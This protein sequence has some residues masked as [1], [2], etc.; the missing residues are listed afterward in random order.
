MSLLNTAIT[1]IN[2]YQKQLTTVGNNISNANT[3]G[4]S[5]QEVIISSAPSQFVG[6]GYEGSGVNIDTI[7]RL[8]DQ[9]A[10]EQLRVDTNLFKGHESFRD[11]VEQINQLLGD[12]RTGLN[13]ALNQYFSS[14]QV[15]SEAPGFIP[16]REAL[17]GAGET[18][19]DRFNVVS[20]RL[21]DQNKTVNSTISANASDINALAAG[22]ANLNERISARTDASGLKQ[23]NDLLDSRDELVRELSEIIGLDV[24]SA[25]N[26]LDI[27]IGNGHALV[28][29]FESRRLEVGTS[30]SDVRE[31]DVFFHNGTQRTNITE[32]ITGGTLGGVLEFRDASLA[33]AQNA[34]GRIAIG[35]AG[36]FNE[37][38]TRGIDLSGNF[39][40]NQ[41]TDYNTAQMARDRV[42]ANTSNSRPQ[43]GAAELY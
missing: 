7:R 4:Y 24:V 38:Q 30:E 39:G 12:E 14:L 6:V 36:A 20:D 3:P 17:I 13:N 18:L 2:A 34:L 28:L 15:A 35:F 37:Q 25:G 5:R 41:F 26:S 19:Q 33:P 16:S 40:N 11:N 31:N 9:F 1:G 27:Y 10:V 21:I 32:R 23:P 43:D 29:G 22:I 42:Q 8:T